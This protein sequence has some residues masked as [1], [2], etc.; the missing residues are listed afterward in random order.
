[1]TSPILI[2]EL[3]ANPDR[4]TTAKQRPKT[5]LTAKYRKKRR[6]APELAEMRTQGS[7]WRARAKPGGRTW[8]V[9]HRETSYETTDL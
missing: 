8:N 5:I 6:K 4:K 3:T 1:L 2:P 9:E 7:G